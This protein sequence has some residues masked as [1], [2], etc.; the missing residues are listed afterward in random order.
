MER[1]TSVLLEESLQ[2][3]N[4]HPEG[5]YLDV[6][7]GG[8]GHSEAILK[9]LGPQGKLVI[10]DC[11]EPTVESLQKKFGQEKRCRVIRSRFSELEKELVA[12]GVLEIDGLIADLGVS[13]LELDDA[14][15]GLSF[16]REG[17]LDMRLDHRLEE[18][19]ADYLG[20]LTEKE[21]ADCFYQFGEERHSR[22]IARAI[23]NDRE[24]K[25]F[26]TT[27]DMAGLADRVLGSL[28]RRSRQKIHP[29]TRIFQALRILVNREMDELE[30]LLALIPRMVALKGRAVMISFHSLEDRMVKRS[31]LSLKQ[32]GWNVLTKKPLV[33]TEDEMK[34]NPRSRSAKLRAIERQKR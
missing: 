19:A 29:A 2:F 32:E 21:L 4:V 7:G 24:V 20:S 12:E 13:S 14:R 5:I 3:L 33:P 28:Y 11:D 1:H 34:E 9:K 22:R 30:S 17:P 31:F 18:T 15:R 25:P 23:V 26:V 27:Q 8:G 6:T 10:A 16:L